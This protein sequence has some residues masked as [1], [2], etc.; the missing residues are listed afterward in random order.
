VQ[1]SA[2]DGAVGAEV[3]AR[4]VIPSARATVLPLAPMPDSLSVAVAMVKE[5]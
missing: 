4:M 2:T 5:G 3:Q 1:I